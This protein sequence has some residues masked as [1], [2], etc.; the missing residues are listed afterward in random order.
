MC[1]VTNV[2]DTCLF[3]LWQLGTVPASHFFKLRSKQEHCF[4]FAASL[5]QSPC[6]TGEGIQAIVASMLWTPLCCCLL[7]QGLMWLFVWST[8]PLVLNTETKQKVNVCF[9]AVFCKVPQAHHWNFG[10]L[11]KSGNECL[12]WIQKWGDSGR[13]LW[14]KKQQNTQRRDQNGPQCLRKLNRTMTFWE[15]QCH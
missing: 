8:Q 14:I 6:Q 2:C 15:Q 12:C 11:W 9:S 7:L 3:T 1:V 5:C 4:I 13:E 10:V